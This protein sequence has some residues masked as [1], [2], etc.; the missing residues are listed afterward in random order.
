MKWS[1]ITV[2]MIMFLSSCNNP[3]TK[4][5]ETHE[6][7]Y[8]TQQMTDISN[9]LTAFIKSDTRAL[10][11]IDKDLI[12]EDL[13]G[14]ISKAAAMEKI[15]AIRVA[16]SNEPTN[17]PRLIE[18]DI[19]SSLYEGAE[20]FSVEDIKNLDDKAIVTVRFSN[21][22]FNEKWDDEIVFVKQEKWVIDDVIFKSYDPALPTTKAIL[23]DFISKN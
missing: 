17:K 6:E 7:G 8:E 2:W 19:F 22:T 9:T 20:H 1:I 12:S 10:D 16:N 4:K 14:L 11:K 23:Q 21:T 5:T 15:D 3:E 13:A 18:G